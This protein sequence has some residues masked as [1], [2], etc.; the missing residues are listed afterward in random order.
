LDFV[1]CFASTSADRP[2]NQIEKNNKQETISKE[3]RSNKQRTINKEQN[4]N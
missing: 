2:T 3:Q 1:G 4:E